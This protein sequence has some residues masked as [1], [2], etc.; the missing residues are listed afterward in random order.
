MG[1]GSLLPFEHFGRGGTLFPT[2]PRYATMPTDKDHTMPTAEEKKLYDQLVAVFDENQGAP[3][4]FIR[5]ASNLAFD[6]DRNRYLIQFSALTSYDVRIHA[7]R[8]WHGDY[9][10]MLCPL[11]RAWDKEATVIASTE[12][13]KTTREQIDYCGLSDRVKLITLDN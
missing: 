2:L 11:L 4:V 7:Y 1:V 5:H 3:V 6:G 12:G 10:G 13:Y 8:E 9:Y